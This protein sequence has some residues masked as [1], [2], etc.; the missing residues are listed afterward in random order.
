MFSSKTMEDFMNVNFREW[1]NELKIGRLKKIN[2]DDKCWI[3]MYI[4]SEKL[5]IKVHK[6]FA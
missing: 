4:M 5:N 3:F 2:S 1:L 6:T